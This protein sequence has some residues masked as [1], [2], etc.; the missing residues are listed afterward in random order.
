MKKRLQGTEAHWGAKVNLWPLKDCERTKEV[1]TR[2]PNIWVSAGM[3]WGKKKKEEIEDC[4]QTTSLDN[5]VY[6]SQNVIPQRIDWGP[7]GTFTFGHRE[8]ALLTCN[9][10]NDSQ[11]P[12]QVI[13]VSSS[14]TPVSLTLN[15]PCCERFIDCYDLM[16]GDNLLLGPWGRKG[17]TRPREKE[18]FHLYGLISLEATSWQCG[19]P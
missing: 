3:A 17:T 9:K 2:G 5:W 15:E 1:W 10:H 8:S 4:P 18:W 16:P 12:W 6:H 7:K 19:I 13:I 11:I 14:K